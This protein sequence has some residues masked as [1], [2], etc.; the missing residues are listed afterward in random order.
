MSAIYQMY[1]FG[2]CSSLF[3]VSSHGDSITKLTIPYYSLVTGLFPLQTHT[4]TKGFLF[5]AKRGNQ[6]IQPKHALKNT[7]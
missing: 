4:Q 5:Q 3:V 7:K 6:G 2:K 1:I